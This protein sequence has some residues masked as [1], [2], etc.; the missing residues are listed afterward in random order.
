MAKTRLLLAPQVKKPVAVEFLEFWDLFGSEGKQEFQ[1]L[2]KFL[3]LAKAFLRPNI[4]VCPK[5]D[6]Q[7]TALK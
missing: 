3:N 1:M 6:L 5:W 4:E 7:P 2:R